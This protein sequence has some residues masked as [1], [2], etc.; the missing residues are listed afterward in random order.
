MKA[1]PIRA[2]KSLLDIADRTRS[3]QQIWHELVHTG[4]SSRTVLVV[5]CFFST[6]DPC[7]A[8]LCFFYRGKG[9]AVR[10]CYRSDWCTIEHLS[11]EP[12]SSPLPSATKQKDKPCGTTRMPG[13]LVGISSCFKATTWPTCSLIQ[14]LSRVLD[15]CVR[16]VGYGLTVKLEATQKFTPRS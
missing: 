10:S 3:H 11:F 15:A 6:L 9:I 5:L 1:R 16:A 13:L 14:I 4:G 7:G 8:C 12:I 2:R